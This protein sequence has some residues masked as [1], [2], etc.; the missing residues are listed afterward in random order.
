MIAAPLLGLAFL[1]K[2]DAAPMMS[3]LGAGQNAFGE[4][5]LNGG[6]SDQYV[7]PFRGP[8]GVPDP[9][10]WMRFYYRSNTAGAIKRDGTLW[11]TGENS[12][13]QLGQGDTTHR[14]SFTKIGAKTDWVDIGVGTEFIAALD[15]AGK[16]WTCGRNDIAAQLGDGT[17]AG[18]RSTMY[19]TS[20]TGAP[21]R[22]APITFKAMAVGH[23]FVLG[24]DTAGDA[25]SWGNN[26]SRQ[27]GRASPAGVANPTQDNYHRK[28]DPVGPWSRIFA[29]GYHGFA[30]HAE[31]GELWGWGLYSEGQRGPGVTSQN[32][33]IV[34]RVGGL[35]WVDA[36]PG[37]YSTFLRR[38]DGEIFCCGRNNDGQLGIGN[39]SST[40]ALTQLPGGP[41]KL[42]NNDQAHTLGIKMDGS[43]WGWGSNSGNRLGDTGAARSSPTRIGSLVGWNSCHTGLYSSLITRFA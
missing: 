13:G 8:T 4:L 15:A 31:T 7:Q 33:S 3:F 24:L 40:S 41:W 23:R 34:P 43:L 38:A 16:I 28:I 5:G 25:W 17:T 1:A 42:V 36:Y 11:A 20:L 35:P 9:D 30:L 18:Q 26:G 22:Q 14:R 12:F 6:G 19:D 10:D 39:T 21:Y 37:E 2:S 29:G 32:A 27:L